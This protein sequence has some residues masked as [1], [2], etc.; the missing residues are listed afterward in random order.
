MAR[1]NELLPQFGVTGGLKKFQEKCIFRIAE[2]KKDVFCIKDTGSG[3][4]LCYQLPALLLPGV[5]IVVS[6][7][8]SLID[9]QIAS[10]EQKKSPPP[11]FAQSESSVKKSEIS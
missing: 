9:D 3:K 6:P 8:I 7:L 1:V 11:F 5:T 4:S 10:L 2:D